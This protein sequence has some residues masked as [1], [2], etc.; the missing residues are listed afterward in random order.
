[1]KDRGRGEQMKSGV[2][3][4]GALICPPHHPILPAGAAERRAIERR[5]EEM[6]GEESPLELTNGVHQKS[7]DLAL[8]STAG[9]SLACSDIPASS[10]DRLL[11]LKM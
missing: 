7:N 2:G 9:A 3:S 4:G 5:G 6:R 10:S 11:K 1:M 8:I